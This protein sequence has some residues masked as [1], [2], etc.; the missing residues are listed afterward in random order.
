MG[1]SVPPP[2]VYDRDYFFES[3]RRQYGR[4]YLEDFPHLRELAAGRLRSIRRLLEKGGKRA[5]PSKAG[6]PRLLD[7]GCAYGPFLAA[8]RDAGFDCLGMDPAE[9]AV[10]YVR[11]SLGI[12]A[13]RGFFP[14]TALPQELIG[15]GFDVIS[16]WY[17]IEHLRDTQGGL[18][19]LAGLLKPGGILALSTPSFSGVSGRFK[20]RRF[21]A[22][23]P[24]DHWIIWQPSIMKNIFKVHGLDLEKIS[25]TGHHPERFPLGPKPGSP[26]YRLAGLASLLCGLGD[27]FEAYGRKRPDSTTNPPLGRLQEQL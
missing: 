6:K 27:G 4:T 23:S 7:I 18:A 13:V 9:D 16:L 1:R 8:A 17:V 20:R 10:R 3:Y 2:V 12:G 24:E 14:H 19:A 22:E 15:E 11:D 5:G 21:L 25:I 26:L